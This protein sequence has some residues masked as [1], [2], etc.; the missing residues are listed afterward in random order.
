[1]FLFHTHRY[2]SNVIS[3]LQMFYNTRRTSSEEGN[4]SRYK[5][6]EQLFIYYYST[7]NERLVVFVA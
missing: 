4:V 1:M 7:L 3:N 2:I 6:L 5:I